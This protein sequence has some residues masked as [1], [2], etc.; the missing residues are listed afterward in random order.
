MK[1]KM[2]FSDY[3]ARIS[4]WHL[5]Q[6]RFIDDLAT[7]TFIDQLNEQGFAIRYA[8]LLQK[9]EP[10]FQLEVFNW[11]CHDLADNL[12]FPVGDK[13]DGLLTLAMR[14]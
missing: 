8:V 4:Q 10:V 13:G 12:L 1:N 6:G 5:L 7:I 14:W 9:W 11:V 2:N 3:N